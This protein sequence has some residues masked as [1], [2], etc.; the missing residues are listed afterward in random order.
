VAEERLYTLREASA[1]TGPLA[2][3]LQAMRSARAVLTDR[4][5]VDLLARRAPANGGGPDGRTFAE[6][7]LAF[8]RGLA[9]IAAWGVVVR[10][11]DSGLC[12]F[13]ARR[14]DRDVYLCWRLGEERIG[15]WHELDAGFRGRLPLDDAF[16][17]E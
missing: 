16:L 12:D 7:A 5:L 3:V 8:S 4:A 15:Y 6:A 13:R 1:L 2:E 14:E 10:D 11:L 17:G 9:Q